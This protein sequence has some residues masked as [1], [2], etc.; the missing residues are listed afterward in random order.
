MIELSGEGKGES[1]MRRR[2]QQEYKAK[3]SKYRALALMGD[4]ELVDLVKGGMPEAY[5]TLVDRYDTLVRSV[6]AKCL[7]NDPMAL[8]DACQETFLRALVRIDDLREQSRFKSWLCAIAHNQALDTLR[9][10]KRLVSWNST[11]G[12]GISDGDDN[13]PMWQIPDTKVNPEERHMR[14]EA[15]DLVRDI[16]SEIPDLYREPINLRYEEDLDYQEI[17]EV[18]GKPLGTIK[19]LIHRGKELMRVELAR[20]AGGHEEAMLLAG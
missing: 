14:D 4:S 11:S 12:T 3:R 19:S 15:N 2:G 5:Q 8:E 17:A 7:K 18:L 6:A 13:Q 16:L 10:R 9:R 20:R 1:E